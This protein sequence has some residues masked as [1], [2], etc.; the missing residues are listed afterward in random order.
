MFKKL[1]VLALAAVLALAFAVPSALAGDYPQKPVT[2]I[3]P[4]GAG[5][6]AGISSRML[7][8]KFKTILG[9]P[10]VVVNKPGAGGITGLRTVA[11]AKPDGYTIGSGAMTSAFTSPFF[12]D[13]KPFDFSQFK[14]VGGYMPQERVLFTTPDKPYKTWDEFIAY[15]KAHPGEVS[16]G[17]GAAQ[18]ALEVIKSVAVKEGLKFKYVM[19]ASGGEASSALLGG[20]VDVCETGTGTPAYQS[21]REGKLLVLGNLGA[22][23]VPFFPDVKNVLDYG[24]P[25]STLIEYGIVVPAGVPEEIRAKLEETL[26]TAMQDQTLIENMTQMGFTPKFVTGA[27]YEDVCKKAV[28]SIPAIVNFNKALEQ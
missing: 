21:A 28:D 9:Q 11:T 7:A 2:M 14:F 5:G 6:M 10:V 15:A 27:E 19:F 12:L 20:H 26:R 18:W 4:W 13:A 1:S 3:V 25:Y 16:V 17:S 22:E 23:T 24:Y 8:E